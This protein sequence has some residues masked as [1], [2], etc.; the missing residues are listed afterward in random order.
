[1]SEYGGQIT[2][3]DGNTGWFNPEIAKIALDSMM[4]EAG[5]EVLFG[6]EVKDAECYDDNIK[7]I[8]ISNG[9]LSLYI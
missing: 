3:S 4:K 8:K 1:M 9:I 7:K 2:Y 6:C 5:C